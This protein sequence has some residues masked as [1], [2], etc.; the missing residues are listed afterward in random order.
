MKHGWSS[1]YTAAT[2]LVAILVGCKSEQPPS[3]NATQR[4]ATAPIVDINRRDTLIALADVASCQSSGDEATAAM[5]DTTP[6]TIIIAGDI[7]YESGTVAEFA[8]CFGRSWGR[9]RARVH[10]SPGN[11]EYANG[12]ASPYF[13]YFGAAAGPAGKGYYS[14][15]IGPW[16]I[17]SLNSNVDASAGSEEE[18]WLKADLAASRARCTL[19]YWH[20]ALFSSG[21]HGSDPRMRDIWRTLY[22]FDADLV[23]TGHDHDYERFAPQNV[24]GIADA[25]RGIREFV[26]GT[27][28]RSF[29]PI[30]KIRPNSEA[31]FS[32]RFGILRLILGPDDYTWTFVTTAPSTVLDSGTGKCH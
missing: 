9:H 5:V 26:V 29:Y 1:R 28:G 24:G 3:N 11:H 6:G 25:S 22:E 15:D 31:R 12:S 8:N 27:G 30:V 7:A 20:H 4:R 2:A 10:P 19:A 17:V 32:G 16:H 21:P 13:A 18:R 23:I 14:F